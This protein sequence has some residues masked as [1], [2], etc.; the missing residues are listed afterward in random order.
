MI[1]YLC[2]KRTPGTK[3]ILPSATGDSGD[4]IELVTW[5]IQQFL[6]TR[7]LWHFVCHGIDY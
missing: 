2:K 5:M 4:A 1:L 3:L 6:K 7:H